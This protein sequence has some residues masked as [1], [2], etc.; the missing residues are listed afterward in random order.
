MTT[1][2]DLTRHLV[3]WAS[4][5]QKVSFDVSAVDRDVHKGGQEPTL[6]KD[7]LLPDASIKKNAG[8]TLLELLVVLA[9]LAVFLGIAVNNYQRYRSRL[10]LQQAQ[11]TFIQTLNRARSDAKRLSQN[12]TI[13]WTDKVL[14]LGDK[15]IQ[16]SQSANI[17]LVKITGANTLT[18]TAPYGRVSSV[19]EYEFELQG[20]GELTSSVYVYGVTG[21]VKAAQ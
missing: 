2:N 20:R 4:A 8:F 14:K 7:Y 1:R 3:G 5:R 13:T 11:Q 16:L 6:Q 19:G 9:I 18:Y 15:E 21:K 12:Q 17:T 10:E